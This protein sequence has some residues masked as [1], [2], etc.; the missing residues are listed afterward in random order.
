[1]AGGPRSSVISLA[2][3]FVIPGRDIRPMAALVERL[4]DAGADP[5]DALYP[6]CH[7]YNRAFDQPE[8]IECLLR[9]GADPDRVVGETGATVRRLVEVNAARYSGHVLELFGLGP[10]E[11]VQ[12]PRV[13]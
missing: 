13:D 1:M 5:N 3:G 11:R 12:A 7:A 8:L 9:R 4:I 2:V 6:A 10:Q